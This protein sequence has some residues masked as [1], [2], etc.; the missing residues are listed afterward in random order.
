M[1]KGLHC[2]RE[3]FFNLFIFSTWV[4][5]YNSSLVKL[6]Q[7]MVKLAR[8]S[9]SKEIAMTALLLMANPSAFLKSTRMHMPGCH[10]NLPDHADRRENWAW[11]P[12]ER[13]F[14]HRDEWKSSISS[15]Q[16]LH[17]NSTIILKALLNR[18]EK[19][20]S[21]SHSYFSFAVCPFLTSSSPHPFHFWC[22]KCGDLI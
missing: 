4:Y 19:F 1:L 16:S 2:K 15:L 8:N 18:R 22:K 9:Y 21:H 11:E 13:A 5:T 17:S 6:T 14:L 7:L 3:F 12:S 20:A 10:P